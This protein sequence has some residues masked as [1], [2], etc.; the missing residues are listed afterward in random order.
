MDRSTIQEENFKILNIN[1][2]IRKKIRELYIKNLNNLDELKNF[3]SNKKNKIFLF[4]AFID[5]IKISNF[6]YL[7]SELEKI[8]QIDSEEVL[9]EYIENK[10][11][12]QNLLSYTIFY[13]EKIDLEKVYVLKEDIP[14]FLKKYNGFYNLEK[15]AFSQ[16]INLDEYIDQIR[17]NNSFI[18]NISDDNIS[19][20]FS[21]NFFEEEFINI[22]DSII[23]ELYNDLKILNV[24][25]FK[26]YEITIKKIIEK[27]YILRFYIAKLQRKEENFEKNFKLEDYIKKIKRFTLESKRDEVL[28]LIKF[29][30][31]L[32][33]EI[34]PD[35]INKVVTK[36]E[37]ENIHKKL[38]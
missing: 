8:E 19:G 24:T 36:E 10:E 6:E 16:K 5:Y 18:E 23:N 28:E 34:E 35:K 32:E 33:L 15:K 21:E 30:L 25:N 31:T 11:N 26:N 7:A 4:T 9:Y 27:A 37:R 2:H 22:M 12:L 13:E 3:F 20:E 14:E 1:L 38:R 17:E 29:F